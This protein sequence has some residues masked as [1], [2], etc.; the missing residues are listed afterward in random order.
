[1]DLIQRPLDAHEQAG[2]FADLAHGGS[3]ECFSDLRRTLGQRPPLRSQA[4]DKNHF[5]RPIVAR[6]AIHDATSGNVAHQRLGSA[7]RAGG[8]G[9]TARRRRR[10]RK[11]CSGR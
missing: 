3:F 4:P 10:L 11:G 8:L 5:D 9:P 6:A 2:L 1:V 7:S